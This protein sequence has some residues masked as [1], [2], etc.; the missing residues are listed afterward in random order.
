MKLK[1]RIKRGISD[2]FL[3]KNPEEE[4]KVEETEIKKTKKK[5]LFKISDFEPVDVI[6]RGAFGIVE[7]AKHIDTHKPYVLKKIAKSSITKEKQVE[8]LK[9]EKEICLNKDISRDF[10]VSCHETLQDEG[11][12]YFVMDFIPGGDLH[13]SKRKA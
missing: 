5:C 11:N 1:K 7:L 3:T 6:T 9:N 8:H 4:S 13:S 10:I 12:L 2:H